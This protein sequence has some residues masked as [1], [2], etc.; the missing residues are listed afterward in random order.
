MIDKFLASADEA[1]ADVADGSTI[2]VSGFG[3]AGL[4]GQ[5]LTALVNQGARDLVI[6]SNNAGNAGNGIAQL[7]ASGRV[8]RRKDRGGT[9]AARNLI[10][11]D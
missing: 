6:V 11:E 4:P 7:V 1:I 9:R 10:R 2:L 3:G 8:R 5:L